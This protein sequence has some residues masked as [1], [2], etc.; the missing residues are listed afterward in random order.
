MN[1]SQTGPGVKT[2]METNGAK[3]GAQK[4][5]HTYTLQLIFKKS[6]RRKRTQK[7]KDNV[8]NK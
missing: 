6:A 8:F 7:G 3:E 4:Y 5:T 2:D 1:S